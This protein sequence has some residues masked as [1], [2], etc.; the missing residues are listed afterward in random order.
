MQGSPNWHKNPEWPHELAEALGNIAIQFANYEFIFSHLVGFAEGLDKE[1]L[2]REVL[3]LTP[4]E[5]LKR[6]RKL[7]DGKEDEISLLYSNLC[8][9]FEVL[10]T[11]RNRY[12]HAYWYRSQGKSDEFVFVDIH[13]KKEKLSK[14]THKCTLRDVTIVSTSCAV[15]IHNLQVLRSVSETAPFFDYLSLP[16]SLPISNNAQRK[17]PYDH[18]KKAVDHEE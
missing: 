8:D 12:I 5:K 17:I 15:Q 1:T 6:L 9:R 4:T 3:T 14:E 11:D 7:V 13:G 16:D 10:L 2:Y 18:R